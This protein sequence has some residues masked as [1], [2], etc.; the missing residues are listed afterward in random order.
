MKTTCDL[1]DKEV[2]DLL[3]ATEQQDVSEALRIAAREHIRYVK[4]MQ[5]IELSGKITVQD[6]WLAHKAADLTEAAHGT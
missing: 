6:D 5:L 4:R 2:A 1:T 3:E